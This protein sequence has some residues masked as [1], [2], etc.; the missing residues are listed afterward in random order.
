MSDVLHV[1]S[2]LGVGGAEATLVQLAAALRARGIS[3][4]VVSLAPQDARASALRAAGVDVTILNLKSAS[5]LPTVLPALV[6]AVNRARPRILQGW[7]YHGNLAATLCHYLCAGRGQRKLFWNLRAS[8]MDE[9]RY[10]RLIRCSAFFSRSVDVVVANSEAGSIFHR[11]RG[12]QPRRFA[13]ID[14]GIDTDKF[15]PEPAIRKEVRA[16]LGIGDDAVVVIHVARVDPM[17]DHAT[18]LAT[19]VELP[20]V[21]GIL[22]GH[23]T[24][25]LAAP[26]NVQVLGLRHDIARLLAAADIIASTSAFGEGFS[27]VVAEG[28][29]AGLVPVATDVGDARRIV[30]ETGPVVPPRDPAAFARAVAEVAALTA[31]ERHRRGLAARER[32]VTN[33]TLAK[34]VD[35]Y[36]RLYAAD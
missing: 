30:G 23:G 24:Q 34:A 6:R 11:R 9:R 1:I 28:M 17:K 32:I 25:E 31:D 20:S 27:N 21:R 10:G 7:M 12:L 15:R 26:A 5:S 14:N 35:D 3:Q 4:E 18:F 8:N 29:S 33:F 16:E 13:V 19:M 22:V 36:A 2:G